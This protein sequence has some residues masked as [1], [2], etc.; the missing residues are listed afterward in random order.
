MKKILLAL[1]VMFGIQTQTQ[2]QLQDPYC[3]SIEIIVVSST[4]TEV[5]LGTNIPSLGITPPTTYTWSYYE[6]IGWSSTFI[7][8]NNG[9]NCTFC[10]TDTTLSSI[11]PTATYSIKLQLNQLLPALPSCTVIDTL[12]YNVVTSEW[13][14][15]SNI[16][17]GNTT[18]ITEI[19]RNNVSDDRLYDLLGREFYNYN[20][21]PPNTIYIKNRKKYLKTR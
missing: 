14:L 4:P 21:I 19:D 15:Y 2:A 8:P 3:D 6:L 9:A 10:S 16:G 5:I 17:N 20:S 11:N 13:E 7:W 1:L 12:S 18:A